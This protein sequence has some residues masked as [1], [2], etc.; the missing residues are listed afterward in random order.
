VG[1]GSKAPGLG[2]GVSA[3]LDWFLTPLIDPL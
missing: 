1:F 3:R 2:G